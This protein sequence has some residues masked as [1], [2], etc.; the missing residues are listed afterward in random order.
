MLGRNNEDR[1]DLIILEFKTSDADKK[2]IKP[3]FSIRRKNVETGRYEAQG[4]V[5]EF[6]GNLKTIVTKVKEYKKDGKIIDSKEVVDLYFQDGEETYLVPFSYRI[7]SRSFFNRI[8][9]LTSGDNLKVLCFR[10]DRGYEVVVLYQNGTIV[11][12]KYSREEL[13]KPQEFVRKGKTERIYDEVDAFMKAKL[14]ELNT[15]L[16]SGGHSEPAAKSTSK[17]DDGDDIGF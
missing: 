6:T 10:D 4:S 3:E 15:K 11:K 17:E 12:G 16:R 13:P 14:E 2:P 5:Y 9:N 8:L 1:G 7:A